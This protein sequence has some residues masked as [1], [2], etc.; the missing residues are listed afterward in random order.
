MIR[1]FRTLYIILS[2]PFAYIWAAIYLFTNVK[3]FSRVIIRGVIC[4]IAATSF[5]PYAEAGIYQANDVATLNTQLG[6]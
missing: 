3:V 5:M 6:I 2:Y 1:W 4:V